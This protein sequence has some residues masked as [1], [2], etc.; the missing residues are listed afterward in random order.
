M[1]PFSC[2]TSILGRTSAPHPHPWS[3]SLQ[4]VLLTPRHNLHHLCHSLAAQTSHIHLTN[5]IEYQS[6]DPEL[7]P[8]V[9]SPFPCARILMSPKDPSNVPLTWDIPFPIRRN[10]VT[11]VNVWLPNASYVPTTGLRGARRSLPWR[12]YMFLGTPEHG[13]WSGRHAMEKVECNSFLWADLWV[14]QV[15]WTLWSISSSVKWN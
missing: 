9:N 12:V 6:L 8:E 11:V 7:G 3:Q 15:D 10:L 13:K 14:D 5:V 4:M 1:G 2:P